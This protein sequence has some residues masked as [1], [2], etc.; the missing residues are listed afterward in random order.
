MLARVFS[1]INAIRTTRT[2]CTHCVA[3]TR[4][5]QPEGRFLLVN[6][7]GD[8]PA[9]PTP[10]MHD[11]EDTTKSPE[12]LGKKKNTSSNFWPQETFFSSSRLL[13]NFFPTGLNWN[14]NEKPPPPLPPPAPHP[15]T[16]QHTRKSSARGFPPLV[17]RNKQLKRTPDRCNCRNFTTLARL[18]SCR[19]SYTGIN[20]N[21]PRGKRAMFLLKRTTFRFSTRNYNIYKYNTVPRKPLKRGLYRVSPLWARCTNWTDISIYYLYAN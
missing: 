10:Q 21:F 4:Q 9:G 2:H 19:S 15:N 1:G 12:R 14:A 17:C 16:T 13:F 11:D 3:V 20:N 8:D 6:S 18:A 7:I 5:Q